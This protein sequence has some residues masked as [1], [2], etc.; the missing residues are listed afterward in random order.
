LPAS[1][2]HRLEEEEEKGKMLYSLFHTPQQIKNK[3]TSKPRERFLHELPSG[4]TRKAPF[5][6]EHSSQQT[7]IPPYCSPLLYRLSGSGPRYVHMPKMLSISTF[8]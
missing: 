1:I 3:T 7:S 8:S 2:W 5:I 6:T 4:N